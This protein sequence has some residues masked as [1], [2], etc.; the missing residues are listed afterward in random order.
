MNPLLMPLVMI[1]GRMARTN[2]RL[3]PPA[4]GPAHGTVG[5]EGDPSL[6]LAVLGE[7]T[8]AGC[9]VSTHQEGFAAAFAAELSKGP[10]RHVS[11]QTVG[12]HG[13]TARRIRHRLLPQVEGSFDRA[14]L[15]AG[16]NDVLSGRTPQE[17][18][19]DL[20]AIIEGLAGRAAHVIVPAIPPFQQFPSLPSVLRNY[21]TEKATALD[22]VSRRICETKRSVTW[23]PSAGLPGSPAEFFAGD[24]FHPSALGYRYWAEAVAAIH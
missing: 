22:A 21:L 3:L 5:R 7:S 24:G 9:G 2:M 10:A 23:V 1:Q 13:A 11:W 8:A 19:D 12:Q 15:L 18:A 20:T 16:A 4:A 17:W 14:V 6:R